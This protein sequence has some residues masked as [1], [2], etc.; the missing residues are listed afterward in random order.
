MP[1]SR[2]L[3]QQIPR[4]KA[5]MQ[6]PQGG[7]NFWCKSPA[8]REGGMV[9]AKIDNCITYSEGVRERTGK[10]AFDTVSHTQRSHDVKHDLWVLCMLDLSTTTSCAQCQ[11]IIGILKI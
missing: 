10:Y 9:M 5:M 2:E 3:P 1:V 4:A 6:K 7:A 11:M 8:V